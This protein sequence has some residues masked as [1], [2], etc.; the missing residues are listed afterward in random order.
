MAVQT[1]IYLHNLLLNHLN[2]KY[3]RGGKRHYVCHSLYGNND[4]EDTNCYICTDK[5]MCK[6]TPVVSYEPEELVFDTGSEINIIP[7]L[8]V[9]GDPVKLQNTWDD[10]VASIINNDVTIYSDDKITITNIGNISRELI[11]QGKS[12]SFF[13]Y[14]ALDFFTSL[15]EMHGT[16]P[17]IPSYKERDLSREELNR[18]IDRY[19][20]LLLHITSVDKSDH[21]DIVYVR[22][23]PELTPNIKFAIVGT[24]ITCCEGNLVVLN[25]LYCEK[26]LLTKIESGLQNF[27]DYPT[28][29]VIIEKLRLKIYDFIYGKITPMELINFFGYVSSQPAITNYL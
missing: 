6:P 15:F 19:P 11:K 10:V 22:R 12:S 14:D 23:F 1:T 20:N 5:D 24:T 16:D 18:I 2:W 25:S 8:D 13:T 21:G 17:Y 4:R 27:S 28:V 7:F 3:V 29:E 9:V 26:G